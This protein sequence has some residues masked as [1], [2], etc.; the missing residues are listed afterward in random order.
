M[1]ACDDTAKP[2]EF[3][4]S[5][6]DKSGARFFGVVA[7]YVFLVSPETDLFGAAH[8]EIFRADSPREIGRFTFQP[9]IPGIWLTHVRD[10]FDLHFLADQ[11]G[12]CAVSG[13]SGSAC[14]ARLERAAGTKISL[15][16]CQ[17]TEGVTDSKQPVALF[18]P[19]LL[20]VRGTSATLR[21]LG[22]AT[23]CIVSQ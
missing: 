13:A 11:E 20:K 18:Y 4:L 12:D 22:P 9:D 16:K 10:G 21:A 19:A 17:K 14:L 2:G 5:G 7:S 1:P 15:A 6:T 8:A 3:L 23:D